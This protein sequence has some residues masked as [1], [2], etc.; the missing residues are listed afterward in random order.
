MAMSDYSDHD[1]EE[2]LRTVA[3]ALSDAQTGVPNHQVPAP[4]LTV[5]DLESNHPDLSML[6][7]IRSKHQTRYAERG[8]RRFGKETPDEGN[9]F[10]PAPSTQKKLVQKMHQVFRRYDQAQGIATGL[11]RKVRTETKS[12]DP[13]P[14]PGNQANAEAAATSVA[15]AVRLL[16]VDFKLLLL[17]ATLGLVFRFFRNAEKP[18]LGPGFTYRGFLR[19]RTWM[20]QHLYRVAL[21]RSFWWIVRFPW[22]EV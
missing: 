8:I 13:K 2:D 5:E 15:N 6:A 17:N 21:S 16:L 22:R 9:L 19:T 12:A 18:S 14:K 4:A 7:E 3:S 20:P 11:P 10:A 1:L